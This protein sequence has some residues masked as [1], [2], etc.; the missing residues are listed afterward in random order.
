MTGNKEEWLSLTQA[1]ERLG[2][3]S[4]TLRRWADAGAIP[5]FRTPGGHRRF[6]RAD[7]DAWL[8]GGQTTTVMPHTETFVQSA[9]GLAREA[10]AEK[11]AADE[12]WYLAFD[13]EEDR[14][15]MRDT[16]RRLFGLALQ[17]MVRAQ[18]R[19]AA[20]QEGRRIGELYG[21]ACSRHGIPLADTVRA[22]FFFR[23]SLLRA[24]RPGLTNPGH[25]DVEDM[26]IHRELRHFLDEVM[27]ACLAHYEVGCRVALPA[28][29]GA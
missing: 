16:G 8:K 4:T 27:Y 26:R 29:D 12:S 7:L 2:V 18:N 9:V 24:T 28:G 5:C 11:Q 13:Q 14:Q 23:D 21:K 19:D 20:L 17:Y 15:Q 10:I 22:F 6:R 1:S 25:Y 3:H